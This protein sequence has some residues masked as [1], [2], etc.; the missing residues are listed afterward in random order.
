MYPCSAQ[1]LINKDFE[2]EFDAAEPSAPTLHATAAE[3]RP[4]GVGVSPSLPVPRRGFSSP[5]IGTDA[6]TPVR[7]SASLAN[8]GGLGG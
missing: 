7:K 6:A 5:S 2:R 3:R 1:M 4:G 8:K